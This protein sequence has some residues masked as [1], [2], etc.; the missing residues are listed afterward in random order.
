VP[1]DGTASTDDH[2]DERDADDRP[3][4]ATSGGPR[5]PLYVEAD[6][7]IQ[8]TPAGRTVDALADDASGAVSV[9][10]DGSTVTVDCPSFGAARSLLSGLDALPLG[11]DRVGDELDAM[12][13][14]VR[15]RVRQATVATLGPGVRPKRRSRL[16]ARLAGAP[17]AA[18]SPRGVLVA[19]VR[20]LF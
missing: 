12:D 3:A 20:R 4:R 14:T 19:A 9:W 18:V 2:D 5:Q 6:L 17:A 1:D 11:P 16:F 15:V 7:S 8:V 13:L 10:G